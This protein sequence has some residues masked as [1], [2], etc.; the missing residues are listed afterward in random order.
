VVLAT[1]EMLVPGY[2]LIWLAA[3]AI[4]TGVLAMA[5]P[6]ALPIQ[7]ALFAGLSVAAVLLGKRWLRDNPIEAAD[8]L[9]NDR[10]GRLVGETVTVVRAIADGGGRVAHGDTEWLAKGPDAEPGSRMRV[11]GHDGAVL[12]VE[13][14]H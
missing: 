11:A 12:I 1:A 2:F 9:M 3:A 8:P 4:L 14:L 6:I 13:H 5:T 7:I 10:G